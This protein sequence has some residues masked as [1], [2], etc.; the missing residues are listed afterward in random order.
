MSRF[1]RDRRQEIRYPSELN[2]QLEKGDGVTVV[3]SRDISPS[4]MRLEGEP[5]LASE[6]RVS[7]DPRADVFAGQTVSCNVAWRGE[8][9][10]GLQFRERPVVFARND[11]SHRNRRTAIRS[12]SRMETKLRSPEWRDAQAGVLLGLSAGGAEIEASARL[13][14][15]QVVFV[16]FGPFLNLPPMR[17]YGRVK[18]LRAGADGST[19]AGIS[20][21][22]RSQRDLE[23]LQRY[24]SLFRSLCSDAELLEAPGALCR[25]RKERANRRVARLSV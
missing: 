18:S 14:L 16:E 10:F 21:A 13:R 2:V 20:F 7:G 8:V 3:R 6:V 12:Q 22:G 17:L 25:A 5:P 24:G 9:E 4:G 1:C 19:I 23:L 11:A 15:H